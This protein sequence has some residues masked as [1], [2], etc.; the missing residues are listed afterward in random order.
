[1]ILNIADNYGKNF[2]MWY[3]SQFNYG[4]KNIKTLNFFIG[5]YIKKFD[6]TTYIEIVDLFFRSMFPKSLLK[7]HFI[8]WLQLFFGVCLK[9]QQA[10]TSLGS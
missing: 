2:I 4:C 8:C 9:R 10:V 1:L 6:V 3:L 5:E 7:S